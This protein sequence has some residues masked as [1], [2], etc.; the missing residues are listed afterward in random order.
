MEAAAASTTEGSA[1][2][3][4]GQARK[5]AQA[6]AGPRIRKCRAGSRTGWIGS[7]HA[8]VADGRRQ[9]DRK[10]DGKT[11]DYHFPFIIVLSLDSRRT[12]G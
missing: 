10:C 8:N 9:Q 11:L 5:A 7:R 6:P 1:A 12:L 2:A 3:E 4:P